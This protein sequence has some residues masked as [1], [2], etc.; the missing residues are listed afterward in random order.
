[1]NITS[2]NN[3]DKIDWWLT[4]IGTE[5]F[6][7]TTGKLRIVQG[8]NAYSYVSI[9]MNDELISR[10]QM[11]NK[12]SIELLLSSTKQNT[13]FQFDSLKIKRIEL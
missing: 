4:G 12:N 2:Q 10:T 6:K 7:V 9:Y 11:I 5:A 13:S 8:T 1:M 3:L